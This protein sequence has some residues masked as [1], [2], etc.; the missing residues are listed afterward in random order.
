MPIFL[1]LFLTEAWPVDMTLKR[2]PQEPEE[3][4]AAAAHIEDINV[5]I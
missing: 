2:K 3:L 1:V 5:G 4:Q